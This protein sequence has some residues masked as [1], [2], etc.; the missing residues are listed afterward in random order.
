MIVV[1]AGMFIGSTDKQTNPNNQSKQVLVIIF[2][3]RFGK[4]LG[5]C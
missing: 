3:L 4:G 5:T 2:P 1:A